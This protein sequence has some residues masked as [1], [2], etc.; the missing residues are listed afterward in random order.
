M[1]EDINIIKLK[2]CL[3]QKIC[4]KPRSRRK[5]GIQRTHPSTQPNNKGPKARSSAGYQTKTGEG[6]KKGRVYQ[7]TPLC[8]SPFV[9]TSFSRVTSIDFIVSRLQTT[10]NSVFEANEIIPMGV[11]FVRT[12]SI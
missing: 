11:K 4:N 2:Y 8:V 5:G 7:L 1:N 10:D 12:L 3:L 6:K 9:T